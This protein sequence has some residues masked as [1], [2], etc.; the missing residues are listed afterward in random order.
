MNL[1]WLLLSLFPS[2]HK[3]SAGV[4]L[5][6]IIFEWFWNSTNFCGNHFAEVRLS[7]YPPQSVWSNFCLSVFHWYF[8]ERRPPSP[9]FPTW[10]VGFCFGIGF[11]VFFGIGFAFL[12]SATSSPQISPSSSL[13]LNSMYLSP[14][15]NALYVADVSGWDAAGSAVTTSRPP[16]LSVSLRRLALFLAEPFLQISEHPLNFTWDNQKKISTR[17]YK[18][19]V[20]KY[21]K[22]TKFQKF[23]ARGGRGPPKKFRFSLFQHKM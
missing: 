19:V 7:Q 11:G 17:F 2:L 5:I 18:K 23:K 1:E 10:D 6:A 14:A 3:H 9:F 21:I 16:L 12:G 8:R 22:Y 4:L 13:L 15:W 20:Y